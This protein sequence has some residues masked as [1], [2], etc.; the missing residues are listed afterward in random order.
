[1]LRALTD[2]IT[3]ISII[4]EAYNSQSV[5]FIKADDSNTTTWSTIGGEFTTIKLGHDC[6]F[7]TP[8][9]QS[10]ETNV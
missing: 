10:Q 4:I 3:S 1:M 6:D 7:F 2:T 9:I 8:R 5:P